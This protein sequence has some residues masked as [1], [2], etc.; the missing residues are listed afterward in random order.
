M[1][2]FF[3]ILFALAIGPLLAEKQ[4]LSRY[5]TII[6]RMPFGQPPP[7]FNAQQ[8][9]SEVSRTDSASAKELTEEQAELQKSVA[10]SVIN[11]DP[12]DG[13]T[14]IGFTDLSDPKVPRHYYMRVGTTRDGW[15]VKEADLLE[16]TM[17]VVKDGVEVTLELGGKSSADSPAADAKGKG[18]ASRAAGRAN[19]LAASPQR[20]GLLGGPR[21]TGQLSSFQG[22]RARREQE[23]AQAKADAAAQAAERQRQAEEAA[24][25]EEEERAAREK[26]REEQRDQLMAI[27]D[28]LRRVREEKARAAAEGSADSEEGSGDADDES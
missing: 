19:L 4:P 13:G 20:S 7:G 24:A 8:M 11:A 14:M 3:T 15:F 16:K 28:E 12:D 27:K 18:R 2:H 6:D 5:Q 10:F 17:T 1:K 26:E 21:G 23:E 9:A 22:R 25:R